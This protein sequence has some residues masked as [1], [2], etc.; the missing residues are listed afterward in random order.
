MRYSNTTI[1]LPNICPVISL[2]RNFGV[3]VGN[4]PT[5]ISSMSVLRL[6]CTLLHLFALQIQ[7]FGRGYVFT[8]DGSSFL[9]DLLGVLQRIQLD[10]VL[11]LSGQ[12]LLVIE[13]F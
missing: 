1:I 10:K 5:Q 4:V 8:R 11:P 12:Y 13:L 2:F 6:P 9:F 7:L 3:V